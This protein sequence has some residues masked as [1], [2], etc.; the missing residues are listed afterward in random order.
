MNPFLKPF[1]FLAVAFLTLLI[2]TA[3]RLQ[4]GEIDEQ[5]PVSIKSPVSGKTYAFGQIKSRLLNWDAKK[6]MLIAHVVFTNQ[7]LAS[8]GDIE[9]DDQYFPIPGITFNAT[10]GFFY[11]PATD[12]SQIPIAHIRKTLFIKSVAVL[13]NA[14]VRVI[15][16]NQGEVTVILEAIKPEDVS[17]YSKEG[18]DGND[19]KFSLQSLFQ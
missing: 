17:R 10:T 18:G 14:A 2:S 8:G 9:E 3:S 4:A 13:P 15:H 6:N 19:N 7:Y 16:T 12:G 5:L 1:F 11:A